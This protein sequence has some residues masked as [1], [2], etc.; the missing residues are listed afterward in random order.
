MYF[1]RFNRIINRTAYYDPAVADSN[2]YIRIRNVILLYFTYPQEQPSFYKT[3]LIIK[4]IF[5]I[6]PHIL[7]CSRKSIL[8]INILSRIKSFHSG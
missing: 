3:C 7:Q 4:C 8:Q 5:R 2:T 6:L 1:Y